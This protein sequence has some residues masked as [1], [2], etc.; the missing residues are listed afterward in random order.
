MKSKFSI[1]VCYQWIYLDFSGFWW[2]IRVERYWC[3]FCASKAGPNGDRKRCDERLVFGVLKRLFQYFQCLTANC[4]SL[5]MG[6]IPTISQNF[7]VLISST[8][9]L[10][11]GRFTR[12][13]SRLMGAEGE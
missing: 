7:A 12:G 3:A 8:T 11:F 1:T 9:G 10:L 2:G 6:D 4:L 5:A 13:I